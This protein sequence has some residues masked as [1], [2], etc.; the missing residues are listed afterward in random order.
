MNADA[1]P[2]DLAPAEPAAANVTHNR[3][4]WWL[5]LAPVLLV[6]ALLRLTAPG[7]GS[8]WGDEALCWLNAMAPPQATVA[9]LAS[10]NQPP[11][12]HLLLRG[13]MEWAG[14]SDASARI[15]SGLAGVASVLF[16]ALLGR[17]LC[18]PRV[19]LL[20]AWFG[21]TSV[22]WITY[23]RE[24]TMYAPMLALALG[25]VSL[26]LHLTTIRPPRRA[27]LGWLALGALRAALIYVHYFGF[28]LIAA[29]F[30]VVL[31]MT[32]RERKA[33]VLQAWMLAHTFA[34][35]LFLPWLPTFLEQQARVG[36]TFWTRTLT[37][38]RIV[39][40][41]RQWLL[42]IPEADHLPWIFLLAGP[43]LVALLALGRFAH[44][45]LRPQGQGVA[46]SLPMGSVIAFL[47]LGVPLALVLVISLRGTSLFEPKYLIAYSGFF[48]LAMAMGL[49]ALRRRWLAA[50]AVG[51]FAACNLVATGLALT[52][53]GY[54]HPDLCGVAS[55][56]GDQW[57]SGDA[58]L[59]THP[60]ALAGIGR[61]RHD[62]T[63]HPFFY[64]APD[65]PPPFYEGLGMFPRSHFIDDLELMASGH[66]RVWVVL[67]T[68]RLK[69][70]FY[71]AQDVGNEQEFAEFIAWTIGRVPPPEPIGFASLDIYEIPVRTDFNYPV[72]WD[73]WG[74]WMHD[75][76]RWRDSGPYGPLPDTTPV[77]P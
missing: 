42:F 47:Y 55:F 51:L 66:R 27:W 45:L 48:Y 26:F 72:L 18:S 60:E 7:A 73:R 44:R 41:P 36:E 9:V 74:R 28:F 6:A 61:Y 53:P 63:P 59:V 67:P 32:L 57:R 10:Q 34:L 38:Q 1:K 15:L 43:G 35:L 70:W 22:F 17:Q 2:A 37:L 19:G 75:V 39:N 21:A 56:L 64:Y 31:V 23:S 12:Y 71:N 24:A 49:D 65:G 62:Q 46:G 4:G 76:R 16:L 68:R 5:K 52:H 20:S 69:T 13:W 14:S 30:V 8:F 33:A 50:A 58:I 25:T 11:G 77:A 29:E 40:L 3:R 54:A